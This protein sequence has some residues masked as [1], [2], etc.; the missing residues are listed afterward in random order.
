MMRTVESDHNFAVTSGS[1]D[2]VPADWDPALA[3][4]DEAP[5]PTDAV[6]TRAVFLPSG[7]RYESLTRLR[8][9][10]WRSQV[11][12]CLG[13]SFGPGLWVGLMLGVTGARLRHEQSFELWW[14]GPGLLLSAL[15][16]WGIYLLTAGWQ[17]RIYATT[18]M[19][20][21]TTTMPQL[22]IDEVVAD[23]VLMGI[24][25]LRIIDV[26]APRSLE[27]QLRC[28]AMYFEYYL[29]EL[30]GTGT[31]LAQHIGSYGG[32]LTPAAN[33]LN[34][35]QRYRDRRHRQYP[36][37]RAICDFFLEQ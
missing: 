29:A 6:A 23:Q 25:R 34:A 32:A 33:F 18:L 20:M 8:A 31:G 9:W 36:R 17:N 11:W 27:E 7:D 14:L 1:P 4:L 37:L 28:A 19:V 12:Y 16:T 10:A 15:A 13:S 22:I 26:A 21:Q 2:D 30:G 35:N 3:D 5:R 24:N